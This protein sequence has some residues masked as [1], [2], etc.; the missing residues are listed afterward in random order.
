MEICDILGVA[1]SY[2]GQCVAQAHIPV[3]QERRDLLL[4]SLC[5]EAVIDSA[6]P[7]VG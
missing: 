7:Y 2:F 1:P 6:K 3:F 4:V 5:T